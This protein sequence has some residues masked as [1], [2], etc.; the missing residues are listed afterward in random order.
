MNEN[1]PVEHR[2]LGN[3]RAHIRTITTP[4]G[5]MRTVALQ[6]AWAGR[7]G[8]TRY[9]NDLR[10]SDVR[11][12]IF[13]LED[14]LTESD[15]TD[16]EASDQEAPGTDDDL[17]LDLPPSPALKRICRQDPFP[18]CGALQEQPSG[19]LSDTVSLDPQEAASTD[20]LTW[21]YDEAELA[22]WR[23][24]VRSVLQDP[25]D[26]IRRIVSA[27]KGTRCPLDE[28][29]ASSVS[30]QFSAWTL[31]WTKP[32]KTLDRVFS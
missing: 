31:W 27:Q 14:F 22:C 26:M 3:V 17:I 16:Q 13:L 15:T 7:D 2:E 24:I 9:A 23:R 29:L 11:D 4:Y 25:E 12:V 18:R 5:Q 28:L 32:S 1:Q 8:E 20:P 6:R 19:Y 21:K 10:E 30:S